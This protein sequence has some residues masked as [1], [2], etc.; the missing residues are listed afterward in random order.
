MVRNYKKK[1]NRSDL[2]EIKLKVA[3]KD[4]LS[5]KY[6][7]SESARTHGFSRTTLRDRIKKINDKKLEALDDSGQS[8]D[9][10]MMY[11]SKYCS[12]QVLTKV[13]EQD[14]S[15]Y[16]KKCSNLQHGFSYALARKFVF[17]YTVLNDITMPPSWIINQAAGVD[18]LQGIYPFDTLAIPETEF[19]NILIDNHQTAD[20]ERTNFSG[21]AIGDISTEPDP[22]FQLCG[23]PSQTKTPE[24]VRPLPKIRPKSRQS[25]NKRK[26]KSKILTS[27]PSKEEKEQSV[28]GR[29]IKMEARQGPTK[30]Q[31]TSNRKLNFSNRKRKQY[32]PSSSSPSSVI[33][34]AET[35]KSIGP[36]ED[37]EILEKD[38]YVLVKFG[39]QTEVFYVGRIIE[40]DDNSVF[41]EFLRKKN[42]VMGFL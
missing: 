31:P 36:F 17:D 16:F 1:T 23:T 15:E 12:N 32:S 38:T 26:G 5:K 21:A 2:D 27:T 19:I 42:R 10:E 34:F 41:V 3:I 37:T 39:G 7:I 13:Q 6:S 24:Q 20:T 33:S 22:L 28:V 11:S 29:K 8:S 18:W 14:L 4:V 30:K 25:L 40:Q 9:E 35:D